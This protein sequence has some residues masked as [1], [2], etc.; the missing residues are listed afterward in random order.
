MASVLGVIVIVACIGVYAGLAAGPWWK[1]VARASHARDFASYYYA[2]QVALSGEDPYLKKNLS[3]A[4]RADR[5]RGSV[6]PFFYPPPALLAFLWVRHLPLERAYHAWYAADH[7]FLLAVMLALQRWG[8]RR[9]LAVVLAGMAVTFTPIPDNDWMGQAN[10][11]VLAVTVWGLWCAEQGRERWGGLL[12]GLAC[13]VK[14]SPALLVAWWLLRGRRRPAAWSVIAALGLTVASL[15]VVDAATQWRFYTEIL[16]GFGAGDYN[17]LRVSITLPANHSIPSLFHEA[18]SQE[19][20]TLSPTAAVLSRI[21]GGA[22]LVGTGW[23][24]R[25]RPGPAG[26]RDSLAEVGA[27]CVLMLILPVYTYEHHMVWMILPYAAAARACLDGRLGWGWRGGLL[28]AYAVQ[29]VSLDVLRAIYRVLRDWGTVGD[30]LYYVVREG[31]FAA[32]LFAGTCC[33][34]A[35]RRARQSEPG[36]AASRARSR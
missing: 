35:A 13:M 15:A 1:N 29:A 20:Y 11:F 18:T 14:M 28:V 31:K 26:G 16:P 32:A 33:L 17:G 8:R 5:T 27:V 21:V 12:L 2:V 19:K 30:V 7:L 10:L 3:Q 25:R 23:M 6:H 9:G 22:L 24:I 4:A 36:S 34:V